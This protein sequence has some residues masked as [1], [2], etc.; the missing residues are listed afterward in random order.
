M[1][2]PFQTSIN[3][4]NTLKYVHQTYPI[5]QTFFITMVFN[6]Y[7]LGV[8]SSTCSLPVFCPDVLF[9]HHGSG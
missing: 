8:L 3:N 7:K 9:T 5:H 6:I 4:G 1:V 2:D